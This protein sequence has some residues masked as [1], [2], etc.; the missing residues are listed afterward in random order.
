MGSKLVRNLQQQV[1]E[2]FERACIK[3]YSDCYKC[4]F[5]VVK[6]QFDEGEYDCIVQ[7]FDECLQKIA[8]EKSSDF[9][10]TNKEYFN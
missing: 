5:G 7:Q 1:D 4:P 10:T 9:K 3:H 8:E 2:V 6:E